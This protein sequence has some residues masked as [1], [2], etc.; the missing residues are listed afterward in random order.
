MELKLDELTID[1]L[2]GSIAAGEIKAADVCRAALS[3]VEALADLNAF[4]TV[5]GETALAQA[6][7]VDRSAEAGG[8]IRQPASLSGVVGLKP[9]YGR[10][11]RYGLIAFGSS[12][13]QIG[14]FAKTVR[15]AARVLGVI[16]GRDHRDAT[17]SDVE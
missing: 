10:V 12:L 7:A 13:D 6:E 16:A 15:D 14:P 11:S 17:S 2:R 3:R 5:T 8:S 1:S 9:T 4:I